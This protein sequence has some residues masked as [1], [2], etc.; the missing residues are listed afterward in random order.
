[1]SEVVERLKQNGMKLVSAEPVKV[2]KGVFA[3]YTLDPKGN[4]VEFS[5]IPMLLRTAGSFQ[6]ASILLRIALGEG[7]IKAWGVAG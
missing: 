1:M 3:L 6:V 5:R 7:W 4:F 2:R